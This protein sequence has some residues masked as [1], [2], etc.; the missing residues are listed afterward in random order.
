MSKYYTDTC[1]LNKKKKKR[2]ARRE[3]NDVFKV[4]KKKKK[5]KKPQTSHQRIHSLVVGWG[6][7]VFTFC[8]EVFI[9]S[10]TWTLR[11]QEGTKNERADVEELNE[12]N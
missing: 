4:Q 6:K 2:G 9:L 1:L 3:W 11:G 8:G 12:V 10:S 7:D 5:L